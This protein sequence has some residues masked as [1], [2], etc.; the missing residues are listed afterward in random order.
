MVAGFQV[1]YF[2]PFGGLI[3]SDTGTVQGQRLRVEALP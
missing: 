2:D 3:V 1:D